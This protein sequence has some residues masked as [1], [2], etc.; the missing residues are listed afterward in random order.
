M[1]TA[2]RSATG[3]VCGALAVLLLATAASAQGVE[4]ARPVKHSELPGVQE[5]HGR[6]EGDTIEECWTIPSL[7]FTATGSTCGYVNDYDEACP[8]LG[9]ISPEVVYCYSPPY[10]LCATITLCESY[11][12]T[13]VYVYEDEYT[14]GSPLACNDD[15]DCPTLYR[16]QLDAVYMMPGHTY[17]IVVD[18]YGGDCG[19]YVLD[20]YEVLCPGPCDIVC[21]GVPEGEPTC[22]DGYD[23]VYNGGCSSLTF[24][25][26]PPGSDPYVVCG[27]SGVFEFDGSTYRDTDWFLIYPCGG[28][29]ITITVEAEFAALYGFVDLREGC[30]NPVF[31]S[32]DVAAECV[33]AS[34][35]EYLPLGQFAVFV[36]P[37]DWLPEYECGSEYALTIE[38][39]TEHCDPTPVENAS[40]GRVKALYR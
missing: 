3:I 36:A 40:W 5:H 27:E 17:Y 20:M 6:I 13:K 12:D 39:Y 14:Q 8:Y 33:V 31:Y 24:S 22:Y 2:S 35:T 34:M 25:T 19:D 1:K 9:S 29:P 16:S 15:Y 7:P 4:A 21:E 38:G 30:E 37:A 32:Y 18:G 26:I 28:M 10:Y 11:Y 23:D